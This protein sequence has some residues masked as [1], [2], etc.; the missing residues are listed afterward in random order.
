[1]AIWFLKY[2]YYC[3]NI[4][5]YPFDWE[6]TDG[7]HI[8]FATRIAEHLPIYLPLKSGYVLSIYNP[9]YH[10][11]LGFLHKVFSV[12]MMEAGRIISILCWLGCGFIAFLFYKKQFS[13]YKAAI[14]SLLFLLPT[15][16]GLL[17]EMVNVSPNSLM[18]FLFLASMLIMSTCLNQ[19][20]EKWTPWALAG[21][22]CSLCFF[23]KQQG[24]IAFASCFV[25]L[26]I[27]RPPLRH[28]LAFTLSAG[29]VAISGI[30]YLEF[31]SHG[32]Y[33]NG[34]L[35][36][37]SKIMVWSNDL[38]HTRF[39]GFLLNH[40]CFTICIFTSFW[41]VIKNRIKPNLW[42]ISIIVHLPLLYKILGN[43]GGGPNYLVTFWFCFVAC[44]A[45]LLRGTQIQSEKKRTWMFDLLLVNSFA[46]LVLGHLSL[47]QTSPID[48]ELKEKMAKSYKSVENLVAHLTEPKILA[49]RNIGSLLHAGVKID[50]EGATEFDYAWQ[51]KDVFNTAI[52]LDAIESRKFDFIFSGFQAY[53][54]DVQAEIDKSYELAQTIEMNTLY[55][56]LGG[57]KVYKPK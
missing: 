51:H 41:Y 20:I 17:L 42:Q 44:S 56:K 40:F 33:L 35:V 16:G 46:A 29:I 53:P 48:A 9:L 45:E 38:A 22:L 15:M 24:L 32:E 7:D 50:L 39:D 31:N 12:P 18:V 25:G 34:V 47:N 55:G 36:N 6:P 11:I 28:F 13:V 19:K 27:Y 49:Y 57:M 8:N 5:C 26:L 1:V 2:L 43:G 30:A 52:I 4:A 10:Y 14:I 54:A 23:A 21:L 3:V 37:V